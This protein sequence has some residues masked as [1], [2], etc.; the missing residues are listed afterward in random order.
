MHAHKSLQEL[1]AEMA[2]LFRAVSAHKASLETAERDLRS[3]AHE[4]TRRLDVPGASSP[5]LP[6]PSRDGSESL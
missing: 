6:P 1:A 3:V 5:S 2:N 4:I